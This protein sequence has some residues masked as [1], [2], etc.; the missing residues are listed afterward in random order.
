MV[1]VLATSQ[2]EDNEQWSDVWPEKTIGE[3]ARAVF[4]HSS[5]CCSEVT[6]KSLRLRATGTLRGS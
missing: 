5:G 6:A 1:V 4:P 2:T 3:S